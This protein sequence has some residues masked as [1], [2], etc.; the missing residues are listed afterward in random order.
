MACE[1]CT[2]TLSH[3]PEAAL[4]LLPCTAATQHCPGSAAAAAAACTALPAPFAPTIAPACPTPL[5]QALAARPGRPVACS[6]RQ[7]SAQTGQGACACRNSHTFPLGGCAVLHCCCCCLAVYG[8]AVLLLHVVHKLI[9]E[10]GPSPSLVKI[11]EVRL[12]QLQAYAQ[13]GQNR[14]PELQPKRYPDTVLRMQQDSRAVLRKTSHNSC[15]CFS[16]PVQVLCVYYRHLGLNPSPQCRVTHRYTVCC[17]V[18]NV[19]IRMCTDQHAGKKPDND[20]DNNV[21]CNVV[22]LLY[23]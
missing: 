11:A 23:L 14:N 13:C 20:A 22:P 6:C 10:V 17:R 21:P 18:R 12:D 7:T 8:H 4:A 16:V 15:S 3:S 2:Y 1:L 19:K 9:H 5:F